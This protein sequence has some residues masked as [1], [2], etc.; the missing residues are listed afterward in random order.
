MPISHD[1]NQQ[2]IVFYISGELDHHA[3]HDMILYLSNQIAL[4]R[5]KSVE[6][7]FSSLSFMDSSGLA[8]VINAKRF[9]ERAGSEL[10]VRDVP[11]HAMRIF[12]AACLENII[13]FV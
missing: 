11:A 6:I 10:V 8:V 7:D 13:S 3:A 4:N 5:S 2:G 9:A 1:L 12:R